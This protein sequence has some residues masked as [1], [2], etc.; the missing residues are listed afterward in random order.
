MD[1]SFA[2]YKWLRSKEYMETL[3]EIQ[4]RRNDG[5]YISY[6]TE[7]IILYLAKQKY[8]NNEVTTRKEIKKLTITS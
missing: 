8:L 2:K 7:S 6:G 3:R 5:E 1:W 4:T